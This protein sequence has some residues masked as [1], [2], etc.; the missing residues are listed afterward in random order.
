MQIINLTPHAIA[1]EGEDGDTRI[2][3]QAGPA[4][5]VETEPGGRIGVINTVPLHAPSRFV[6]IANLPE[7]SDETVYVVSQ[8]AALAIAAMMPWRSDVVYPGAAA[9]DRARRTPHGLIAVSR[10]IRAV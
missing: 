2:I 10:L 6:R 8:I 3:D 5:R 4:V 7:Q 9:G 1:L